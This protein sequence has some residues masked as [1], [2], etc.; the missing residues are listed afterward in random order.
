MAKPGDI[1]RENARREGE[2]ASDG[3]IKRFA[4]E[5]TKYPWQKSLSDV[6]Q[7]YPK[8][9]RMSLEERELQKDIE[10]FHKAISHEDKENRLVKDICPSLNTLL[11][12]RDDTKRWSSA[13]LKCASGCIHVLDMPS[14][15]EYQT[16]EALRELLS[17]D[18]STPRFIQ[19]GFDI[20]K[21]LLKRVRKQAPKRFMSVVFRSL[22]SLLTCPALSV[23]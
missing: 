15:Q 2:S 3:D 1:R 14:F 23:S 12:H 5:Q 9:I 17:S 18:V 22:R 6:N 8:F 21:R 4:V 7:Y 13:D 11:K 19:V 20:N 16:E 10:D